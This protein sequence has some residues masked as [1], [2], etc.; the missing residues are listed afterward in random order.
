MNL[1]RILI[2]VSAF[3]AFIAIMVLLFAIISK[4]EGF[5]LNPDQKSKV[6]VVGL[7]FIG[8]CLAILFVFL[9]AK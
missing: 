3:V 7:V 2:G 8:F 1:E 5:E 6:G 4:K 9:V